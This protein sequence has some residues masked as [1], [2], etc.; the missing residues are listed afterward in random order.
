MIQQ[1]N[2]K[3]RDIKLKEIDTELLRLLSVKFSRLNIASGLKCSECKS[4]K[5]LYFKDNFLTMLKVI[6]ANTEFK[7]E[8]LNDYMRHIEEEHPDRFKAF[9]K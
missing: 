4:F 9:L 3:E 7:I 1:L 6:D 2:T 8:L 5:D